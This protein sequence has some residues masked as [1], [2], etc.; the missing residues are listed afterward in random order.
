V[1]ILGVDDWAWRRGCRYGT[2]LCDLER[3][4]VVGLL[5]DRSADSLAAWLEHHPSVE[6]IGRERG[7]RLC[8]GARRGAPQAIQVVDR[9]HLFASCSAAFLDVAKRLR[10]AITIANDEACQVT[11]AFYVV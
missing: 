6:I 11:A 5:A 7:Q 2:I 4:C 8:R 9:W 10:P 1:R 3:R